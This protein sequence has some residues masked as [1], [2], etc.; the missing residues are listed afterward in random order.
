MTADRAYA[1]AVNKPF[2]DGSHGRIG[3]R[4]AA[5]TDHEPAGGRPRAESAVPDE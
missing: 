2:C 5:V 4:S 1:G 3:R